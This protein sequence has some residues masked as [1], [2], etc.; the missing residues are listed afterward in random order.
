MTM[1]AAVS[2]SAF[3]LVS[4]GIACFAHHSLYPLPHLIVGFAII[5]KKNSL[6]LSLESKLR[7]S[8]KKMSFVGFPQT[9][10]SP[11]EFY[12]RAIK[13]PNADARRRL[14]ADARQSN[15][16]VYKM[17]VL[18]A[19]VEERWGTDLNRLKDLLK[20]GV[21]VFTNP[22][23][24]GAHCPKVSRDQWLTEAT[25]SEQRGKPLTAQALRQVVDENL[26]S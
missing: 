15:L 13:E 25:E 5:I 6:H 17:Y 1:T 11:S 8:E 16:C 20:K 19:E 9:G 14:F 26:G 21:I 2:H 24:Q 18:A 12:N 10:I 7:N 23:G 3:A 22:A 4:I